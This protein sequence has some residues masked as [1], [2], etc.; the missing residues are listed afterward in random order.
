[1]AVP[2]LLVTPFMGLDPDM[3]VL[4]RALFHGLYAVRVSIMGFAL[5]ALPAVTVF[6]AQIVGTGLHASDQR[7]K[8]LSLNPFF[9]VRPITTAALIG[10]K[11][12]LAA[13]S[14]LAAWAVLLAFEIVWLALLPVWEGPRDTTLGAL[15]LRHA[16]VNGT[17]AA[18]MIVLMLMLWTWKNQIQGLAPDYSGRAWIVH[19]QTLLY[20]GVV[21]CFSYF[22]ATVLARPEPFTRFVRLLP[23][24]AGTVLAVKLLL[25][26]G[27]IRALRRQRLLSDAALAKGGGAWAL[28]ALGLFGGVAWMLPAGM[29]PLKYVA[30]GVALFLPLARLLAAPL[31]LE[32]NRHR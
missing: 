19:G 30:L 7:R 15:I 5:F 21:F 25:A 31:S 11:L 13:W 20:L 28:V 23:A 32:W 10:A 2:C 16:T 29:A 8:D 4:P 18:G 1:V 22:S 26:A 17:L 27:V 9:A 12:K 3:T 14:T 6:F 24:L